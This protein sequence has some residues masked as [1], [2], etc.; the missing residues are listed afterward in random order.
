MAAILKMLQ[1]HYAYKVSDMERISGRVY[2]D[3]CS[4]R[5][6]HQ[7]FFSSGHNVVDHTSP[8][9]FFYKILHRIVFNYLSYNPYHN[10]VIHNF[11]AELEL[12]FGSVLEEEGGV[13]VAV[14]VRVEPVY[15][16][17]FGEIHGGD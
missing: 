8:L 17:L 4:G 2:S 9:Q 16:Y 1:N 5:A 12:F 15:L 14:V 3:I 10:V 11:V 13:E 7:F 6:F